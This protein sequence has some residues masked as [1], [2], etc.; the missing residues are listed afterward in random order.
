MK[1]Q[2]DYDRALAALEA[3]ADDRSYMAEILGDRVDS[4]ASVLAELI[5][6]LRPDLALLYADDDTVMV[7]DL[8]AEHGPDGLVEELVGP[9]LILTD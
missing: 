4:Y 3:K 6:R 8:L 7:A 9:G 1:T 5:R 2:Q